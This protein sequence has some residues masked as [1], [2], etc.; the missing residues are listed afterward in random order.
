MGR[1]FAV[2]ITVG[3][4][5]I[6]DDVVGA[7]LAEGAVVPD[8]VAVALAVAVAVAVAVT[9]A[10]V[11]VVAVGRARAPVVDVADGTVSAVT[12]VSSVFEQAARPSAAPSSTRAPLT[13]R[14]PRPGGP[15]A[16]SQARARP[17]R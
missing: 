3:T 7:A 10:T 5:R 17:A 6:G 16:S 1:G 8:A 4:A 2:G 15:P 13:A 9:V 11:V 12:G 14:P